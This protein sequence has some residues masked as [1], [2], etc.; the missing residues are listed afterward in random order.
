VK[1]KKAGTK[2]LYDSWLI[3]AVCGLLLLGVMMVASSSVMISSHSFH[4]PF[5][6]L[7][8]H[9]IYLSVGCCA[10]LI[11]M[12][13]ES[14]VWQRWSGVLLLL[15]IVMLT[16]VL[17]PG[18]GRVVNGSRRWLMLGPIGV[19][20]SEIAK[21]VMIFYTSAYLVREQQ[22][23][24]NHLLSFLKP[25]FIVAIV[26]MLLLQEPDFG[27]T[28]VIC[29]TVM[30]MLFLTGVKLRYYV[31]LLILVISSLIILAVSSPYRLARL[32]AFLN[33][34][35]DQYNSGYQLTQALIA[36]GRG[37]WTGLGVGASVQK[38]MYLPEAHTDFVF[39]V[40]A[41]ELGLC[42][43]LLVVI[44]YSIL[45]FRG[46]LIGWRAYT[47]SRFFSAFL[48]YGITCWLGLQAA[49]NMGVNEG[50]LPTKGLTLP[51][52]SYGGASLI[53]NCTAIALLLRID[54][55]N[56]WQLFR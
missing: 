27:A 16:L 49:I 26:A 23:S 19:Q 51:L 29:A 6:F 50:L 25:M 42:G 36:F 39:A 8:R 55:E 22:R 41:E 37:G 56:R 17:I 46:F 2:I 48:A 20:V 45:V 1:R 34:W 31:S 18:L 24:L 32:T 10:A 40:I 11:V 14:T 28:V 30:I 13:L 4:Q 35:A 47:Q 21:L 43:I 7:I 3:S 5:H 9:L 12:R 33:P 15:T 54:Y 38:L 53:I 44:L 52:L